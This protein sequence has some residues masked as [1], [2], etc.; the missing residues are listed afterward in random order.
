MSDLVP[1]SSNRLA[2]S[3]DSDRQTRRA[4]ATVERQAALIE[5][6]AT[7]KMEL[8]SQLNHTAKIQMAAAV[9]YSR[10]LK[11]FAPEAAA[12]LDGLDLQTAQSLSDTL[13]KA[14]R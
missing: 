6:A 8:A 11:E 12:L 3:A 2:L 13:A 14:L 7:R 5:A 9:G 10:Q 4:L 1:A